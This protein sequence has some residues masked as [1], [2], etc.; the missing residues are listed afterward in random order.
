[1][2]K[3]PA[4]EL[5]LREMAARTELPPR[6]IR[7]YIAMGLLPGPL[8]TGRN[9][10]YG[11][12]HLRRLREIRRLQQTGLTLRQIAGRAQTPGAPARLPEPALWQSYVVSAD[13]LV[14][15]RGES[16]PWRL[17]QV[18]DALERLSADLSRKETDDE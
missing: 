4:S 7:L 3:K 1:M 18:R 10:A 11:P 12:E 9:A 16:S 14:L 8:R 6:T 5:S 17:R 15:V 2:E 13:V